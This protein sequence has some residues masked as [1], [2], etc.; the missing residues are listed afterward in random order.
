VTAC[1]SIAIEIARENRNPQSF[2]SIGRELLHEQLVEKHG[3]SGKIRASENRRIHGG[4]KRCY[5]VT[6]KHFFGTP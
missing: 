4:V 1:Q 5:F 2:A 6:V 3:G